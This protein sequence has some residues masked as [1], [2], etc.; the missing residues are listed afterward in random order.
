MFQNELAWKS[1]NNK[2]AQ[3]LT[4]TGYPNFL[5]LHAASSYHSLNAAPTS[6]ATFF[7]RYQFYYILHVHLK[8][9]VFRLE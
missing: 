6:I 1:S 2:M 8:L 3:G 4:S 7:R 5:K 9:L